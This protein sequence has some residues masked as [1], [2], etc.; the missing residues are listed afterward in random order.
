MLPSLK[1][2]FSSVCLLFISLLASAQL[3]DSLQT[4]NLKG[5]VKDSMYNFMLTSATVAVYKDIDSSLIQFSIPDNFGEFVIQPLPVETPLRMVITHVG[6]KP[7][8]KKFIIHKERKQLDLGLLYMYQNVNAEGNVLDEVVI[9]AV[10]PVRMNGDTVE[11]NADAFRMDAN[12]TAE[13]LMRRLPGFTIWGDGEITYRGKKINMVYVEGKPFMGTVD[14]TIATQNLPKEALDKIQ[15]YQ[16]RDEKNPLDSTMYANIKLKEDKKMGYF[17]K[18]SAGK[19]TDKRYAADGMLSGFNK[20]LQVN[21]V[22]ALN[23]INKLAGSTDVL[24]KNSSFKGE[25][26]NMEYQSDFNM[27]GL[28]RSVAAGLKVQY[29]F[30]PDAQYQKSSRLN[31]DYFLNNN[32]SQINN[33]SVVNNFLEADT[34]LTKHAASMNTNRSFGQTVN[35]RYA[36]ESEYMAL[37]I[38]ASLGEKHNKSINEDTSHQEKTGLGKISSS[39]SRSETET[40][41]QNLNIGINYTNREIR[42]KRNNNRKRIPTE[43]T[44][45][46]K[47]SVNDNDGYSRNQTQYLSN[48]NANENK[49]FDRVYDQKDAQGILHT[50]TAGYP[51]LTRLLFNNHRLGGVQLG[52]SGIF[53]FTKDNYTDEVLDLDSLSQKYIIN[54]Y[55]TNSSNFTS[56]NLQP[57]LTISKIFNKG[58]TNRYNKQVSIAANLKNQYYKMDNR[59]SHDFQNFSYSYSNFIPDAAIEYRNHQY[60]S[61]EA[62]YSLNLKTAVTYPGVNNIAPLIDSTDLWYRP[63]GNPGIKPQYQ[64]DLIFK[65]N[66]TTRTRKNPLSIDLTMGIGKID[67][68]ITDS[69][70]YDNAGVRTVYVINMDGNKYM[71][72]A[73]GFRKSFEIKKNTTLEANGRYTIYIGQ[74]PQYINGTANLSKNMDQTIMFYIGFRHK[75]VINFKAEQGFRLYR[76]KQEGFNDNQFKNANSYSRLIGT[77]QVPKNLVWSSNITF[78]RSSSNNRNPVNF[79]IWNA[80]L[81]YRFLTGNRGEI[82]FAALDL[83]RQNKAIMNTASTNTQ[84]FSNSNVLQQYYMLT[85]SYYPRKF[86]RKSGMSKE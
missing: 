80:S 58:L 12:A 65:Y 61:Y 51:T 27:R 72:G 73:L 8:F 34:I 29:D 57:A 63:K 54:N 21:T 32:N 36:M 28:N 77:L 5:K 53:T 14:P 42:N 46:Y 19:G 6:Y 86:G 15:V 43:F 78:N 2:V 20:K 47:F 60:G 68:N 66:Y 17:G 67:H 62:S 52:L 4:G 40:T 10:P 50:V 9:K 64:K 69:S 84:T 7:F 49:S 35:T 3:K 18:L 59:S 76:S 1:K 85:L 33:N 25:G 71:N 79:A 23:N 39:F 70:S 38:S 13:D 75:E 81:T 74:N 24:M 26:A 45:G 55:L 41:N 44:L 56:S 22:G 48:V 37:A 31:T 82:K 11:F 83:L 16:Q 30:I